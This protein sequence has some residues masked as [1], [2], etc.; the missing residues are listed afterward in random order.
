MAT[1]TVTFC[2]E[3]LTFGHP[4]SS[5][6]LQSFLDAGRVTGHSHNAFLFG[7]AYIWLPRE[8]RG[9]S[10]IPRRGEGDWPLAQ[11]LFAW[12]CLHSAT[13]RAPAH[14]GARKGTAGLKNNPRLILSSRLKFKPELKILYL[15]LF[16]GL[17]LCLFLGLV[18]V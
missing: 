3:M 10:V 11:C 8:L 14:S 6:A 17:F 2:L 15:G 9:T 13:Q 16:L 1:R 7:N 12:K 4:E 18:W 5:G